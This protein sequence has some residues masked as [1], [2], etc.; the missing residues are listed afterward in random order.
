MMGLEVAFGENDDALAARR[1]A[2]ASCLTWLID[3]HPSSKL[4]YLY[5]FCTAMA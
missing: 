3:L 2:I 1:A 5:R 4:S